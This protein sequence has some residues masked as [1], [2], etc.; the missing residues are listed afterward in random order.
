MLTLD[1]GGPRVP[2]ISDAGLILV[3]GLDLCGTA[4]EILGRSKVPVTGQS[5]LTCPPFCVI[6]EVGSG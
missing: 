2:F 1:W 3:Q 5:G 6:S 4:L